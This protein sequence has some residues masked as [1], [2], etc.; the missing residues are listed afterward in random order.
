[1]EEAG[2]KTPLLQLLHIND[3][4]KRKGLV[5]RFWV[6]HTWAHA[7]G[8]GAARTEMGTGRRRERAGTGASGTTG[9]PAAWAADCTGGT[10]PRRLTGLTRLPGGGGPCGAGRTGGRPAGRR[11]SRGSCASSGGSGAPRCWRSDDRS[12]QNLKAGTE[13]MSVNGLTSDQHTCDPVAHIGQRSTGRSGR[14]RGCDRRRTP[15]ERLAVSGQRQGRITR[16]E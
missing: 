1:M 8:E 10:A 2:G 3:T 7:T 5:W 16:S 11:A 14:R 15:S 9:T 13:V 4:S 12:S 6:E